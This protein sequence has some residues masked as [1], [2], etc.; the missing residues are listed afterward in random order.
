M[1]S[2]QK[3]IAGRLPEEPPEIKAIKSYVHDNF[4]T[5]VEVMVRPKEII[6]SSNS[7]ALNNTLRLRITE[8]KKLC[9]P[10]KRFIFR[11]T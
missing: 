8:L 1:D 5:D 11:L 10:D 9:R 2:L 4:Q 6:I 3:I 7:A